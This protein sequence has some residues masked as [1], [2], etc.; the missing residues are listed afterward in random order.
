[1]SSSACRQFVLE[2]IDYHLIPERRTK[3]RITRAIPRERLSRL[4]YVVGG[5]GRETLFMWLTLAI[6]NIGNVSLWD[7]LALDGIIRLS[8]ERSSHQTNKV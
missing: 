3:N 6:F 5:E 4:L 2:A 7:T 1:M 8:I